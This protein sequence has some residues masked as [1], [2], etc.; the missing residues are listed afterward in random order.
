MPGAKKNGL[1]NRMILFW[2]NPVSWPDHGAGLP[3]TRSRNPPGPGTARTP[4]VAPG[5]GGQDTGGD[6]GEIEEAGCSTC[7]W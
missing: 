3:Q 4:G 6:S 5:A 1:D 7:A 2:R